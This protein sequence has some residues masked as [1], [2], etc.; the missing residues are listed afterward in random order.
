[1]AKKEKAIYA[2]GELSR[3]RKKLGD[4]D[5]DEAKRM[6]RILGGEVGVERAEIK[7]SVKPKVRHE[8]V[9][10]IVGGR[11]GSQP[12]H[13]V[14]TALDEET[15]NGNK[16]AKQK[17]SRHKGLDPADNPAVPVRRSYWERVKID[18][19]AG[20]AEFEIKS[21]AQ[22]LQSMLSV[23]GAV[24][25][26][27]SFAFVTKRMNEYYKRI[28]LLVTSTRTLLPRNNLRR[29]ERMKKV[30]IFAFSV[31]DVIRYWNIERIASD[32][33]R[34]QAHPR[35]AKVGDFSD[36]LR[37]VY[38]PLYILEQLDPDL[39][40][41]E[42]YKLLYKILYLENPTEAKDK[43][44]E[45][46]R[47]A[48]G[49]YGIIRRDIRFL[50]Y[51]LLLKL[52]SDRWISY[53]AFFTERKNRFLAF[54]Q[55][56]EK[57][58][59]FPGSVVE[60]PPENKDDAN[61]KDGGAAAES[62]E[63]FNEENLEDE[64]SEE[65]KAKRAAV[66]A[67]KRAVERGLHT[68]EALFPKAGWD[69]ISLYPDL[70][71]YFADIFDLKKG[72]ELLSPTDPLQQIVVLMR[73]L[74]ELFFGLRYVS[75]GVVS[76]ADGESE[77]VDEALG[78]IIGN[79]HQ[80]IDISFNKE[81]LPRLDEYCRILDSAVESRTSSYARRILNELHWTKRLYFLPYYHFESL[82]PPPFQK[83]D[84][85]PLYPR[86]RQLRKYLTAV[87]A[88]IEQGNKQGGAEANA[89]CNGIDNP[90]ASYVFQVPN[91]LSIRL[92]A[93]LG[94][95]KNNASLIFFTLAVAVVLDHLV[96]NENSWAYEERTGP[97]FRSVDGAGISPLFGVDTKIDA[98][99]IFKLS[100]K[101]RGH[102]AMGMQDF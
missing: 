18:K 20:Q 35:N 70:Y 75:F 77:R 93:L 61:A 74:E 69:R 46:I 66:E 96:N 54:I 52:L 30:S 58:Q 47:T 57:D 83:K 92:D 97:L 65:E 16:Y 15:A 76:G 81:Y 42:S 2:P 78:S 62:D 82:S 31:L 41:K 45:L 67:E 21:P 79:W 94:K 44:Q 87:A 39:H 102:M 37:A 9:D 71:P 80:Y 72:Y 17:S 88:G 3:V 24:P 13:R 38:K 73:I 29:N 68:L 10:V 51:P 26:Q 40:I 36:I 4:L 11:G 90:W 22:V 32:L 89:P 55:A 8:T 91:P 19:Y 34:I 6:A 101:Q 23:F 63:V 14:E 5:I 60:P 43:Y 49:S 59:V 99:S 84:I 100:I 1:M 86:I 95:K 7:P 48:L 25:D 85:T 28:E 27:V 53:E 98:D 50:L 64:L 12:K 56:S 33:A